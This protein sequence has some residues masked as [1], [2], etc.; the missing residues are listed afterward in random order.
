[1]LSVLLFV[2][3]FAALYYGA[4]FLVDGASSISRRLGIPPLII[5]LTVVSFGTSAPEL[6]VNVLASVKGSSELVVGNILGSNISNIL[7]ILGVSA[8]IYE[9]KMHK[10]LFFKEIPFSLLAVFVLAFIANDGLLAGRGFSEID[11]VDGLVLLTFFGIFI[12]YL[13]SSKSSI[14]EDEPETKKLSIPTSVGYIFIGIVG[15]GVGGKWIVD[16]AIE[17]ARF[18]NVS[19]NLIGLTLVALG[20]SFPELVT[21]VVAALKKQGDILIGNV[22]GS[23]IF[24]IFF[25][26]GITALIN[27]ITFDA[28]VNNVDIAMVMFS[29]VF[30]IGTVMVGKKAILEKWNGYLFLVVYALY[31]VFLVFRD[32]S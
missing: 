3:G 26:L 7:L 4:N 20:T 23:N 18:F 32:L 5:G 10:G 24:N 11:R 8:L 27:P 25:I 28:S 6:V 9:L 1:M 14:F 29:T 16:G 30:L 22:V 15:L 31:I 13:F 17:I 12:Y 2:L 21:S 19:E